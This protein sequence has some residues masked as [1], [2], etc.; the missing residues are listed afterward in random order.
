M[1]W[2]FQNSIYIMNPMFY[3]FF[4][5]GLLLFKLLKTRPEKPWDWLY[6]FSKLHSWNKHFYY[7]CS[8]PAFLHEYY[9]FLHVYA[10]LYFFSFT[11]F[12]SLIIICRMYLIVT[13]Y[14]CGSNILCKLLYKQF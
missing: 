5:V 14:Y 12:G 8:I 13:R 6:F 4:P 1:N 10:L 11:F 3:S 7:H 2:L 9:Y